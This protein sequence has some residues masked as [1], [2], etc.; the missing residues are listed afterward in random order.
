MSKL[1]EDNNGVTVIHLSEDNPGHDYTV[2]IGESQ[3]FWEIVNLGFQNG[4]VKENG[5][6][7]ITSEALL[8]ILIHRTEQLNNRFSCIENE[9]AIKHLKKALNAFESRTKERQKRGVEGL[10]KA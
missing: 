5:V 7:G 2:G 10:E 8:A 4:A 6:N 3:A 1:Y 9:E